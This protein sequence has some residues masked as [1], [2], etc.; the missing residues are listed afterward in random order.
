MEEGLREGSRNRGRE[1]G[2]KPRE[3][4]EGGIGGRTKEE[5]KETRKEEGRKIG[6]WV[7]M[8]IYIY[9]YIYVAWMLVP[10]EGSSCTSP[11]PR[12]KRTCAHM[13]YTTTPSNIGILLSTINHPPSTST[14]PHIRAR[15]TRS[16][17][18]WGS[19][20]KGV[21]D[22]VRLLEEDKTS[23]SLC[24]LTSSRK[25][26]AFERAGR[27]REGRQDEEGERRK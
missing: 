8:Y 21:D 10:C 5:I 4:K 19:T 15:A 2:R 9:V 12:Q 20:K 17:M 22:F 16:N 23:D 18:A 25:F 7:Y 24:I 14:H 26:G 13:A 1:G 3:R 27:R 11:R 6:K